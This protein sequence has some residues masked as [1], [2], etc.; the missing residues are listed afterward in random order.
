[1]R[2][3]IR[4]VKLV[5]EGRTEE[6]SLL[7]EDCRI[8]KWIPAASL[9]GKYE[10]ERKDRVI[11]GKGLYLSHGF[12]DMHVHGGGG[13]DFMDGT[14]EAWDGIRR[15]HMKHG[16]TGLVATTMA[17]DMEEMEGAAGLYNRYTENR[18]NNGIGMGARILGLHMEGPYLSPAQSGAQD[19]AFIRNPVPEEY[20][21][22]AE[23]CPGI[24]RWTIAPELPGA[25][26]MGDYLVSRGI[27]PSIGHSDAVFGEVKEAVKHG[28]THVTHLY[29]AMSGITRA[30]GFRR[31]GIIESAYVLPE[32]TSEVIADGCHLPGELLTM[33]YR[34]IG[35]E[36]L[37]LVTDAMRAAGQEE[38][39]SILGSLSNGQRVLVED[40]VAKMP[41]RKA[42]AGS[43]CTADR[44]VRNMITLAGA[45]LPEAVEM[46][47][48][49]PARIL[50]LEDKT[51]SIAPGRRADL[52][53]FDENIQI[54]LVMVDGH[55][56]TGA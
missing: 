56:E 40:G 9:Y 11:D 42:F 20:K 28:Y 50:G 1:M 16:T 29:S 10:K 30:G 35:P 21:K 34:F 51:G 52:V 37:A 12:I 36:R 49:T 5:Q 8:G 38:G 33:A 14:P 17:S 47:T 32:L 22:L 27:L 13:Y 25:D 44:L 3:W 55:M 39:E 24:L 19:R 43:V 15:L 31:G 2:T 53:L 41:D 7:I 46:V 54:K 4:N 6:G 18:N 48:R 45:S 23:M 26:K